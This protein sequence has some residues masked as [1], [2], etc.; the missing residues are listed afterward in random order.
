MAG[1]LERVLSV[2][3]LTREL[4][5]VLEEMTAGLWVEGEVG[6][7]SRPQSGH[8]YFSLKDERQEAMVS[9]VMYRREVLRFGRHLTEGARIQVRGRASLY[10][11]RGNL[12]WIADAV[13]PAGQGALLEALAKLRAKLIAEG[14]TDESRKRPLPSDPRFIGVVTSRDGAAFFDIVKVALRR[15][16]VRILLAPALVQGDEA[17]A[18]IVAALDAI[19]RVAGIDALIVGRGGGSQEDLFAFSDERVVRRIAAC[20]VPVISAVGHEVDTSLADLVADVRAATPSQAAELLVPDAHAR[21]ER[22]RRVIGHLGQATGAR[23]AQQQVRL[24]K[25]L[26]RIGDPRAL[27]LQHEQ[28]QEEL[29]RRAA[30]AMERT[31]ARERATATSLWRRLDARHPKVVLTTARTQILPL[32]QRLLAAGRALI[33]R[34]RSSV[35]ETVRALEA[36]SPVG[37]LERGYALVS[38]PSGAL[39]RDSTLVLPGQALTVRVH[40]GS[41]GV[42]VDPDPSAVEMRSPFEEESSG[43]RDH[44]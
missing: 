24:G 27:L 34:R 36:L 20:R 11:A 9:A 38:D 5:H 23:V 44:P 41:F 4:K 32:E 6:S 25:V 7:V 42:T 29:S 39:V 10:P 15:S 37:I 12:Q 31:V 14:L 30:R 17:P 2:S 28:R 18:S 43:G 1:D 26:R 8:V 21:R 40:R 16:R 35:R 19:E 22:L 3:E 33:E 13:R